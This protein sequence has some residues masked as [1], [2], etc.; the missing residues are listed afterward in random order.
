MDRVR[1]GSVDAAVELRR[2][3]LHVQCIDWSASSTLGA[4]EQLGPGCRSRSE[5]ALVRT[6]SWLVTA[7]RGCL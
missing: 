5:R 6:P 1:S 2:P 3:P 7:G 4:R